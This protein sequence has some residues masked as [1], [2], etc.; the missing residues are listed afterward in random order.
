MYV[1]MYISICVHVMQIFFNEFKCVGTVSVLL[2]LLMKEKYDCICYDKCCLTRQLVPKIMMIIRMI[3]SEYPNLKIMFSSN[4]KE[5][6][7]P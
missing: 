6:L 3:E 1:F 4:Q 5:S 7:F 2:Y